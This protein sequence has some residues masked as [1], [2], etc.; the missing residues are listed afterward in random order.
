MAVSVI[1]VPFLS[2]DNDAFIVAHQNKEMAA[3]IAFQFPFKKNRFR[4]LLQ[5]L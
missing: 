2:G 3:S 1:H 5:I 4:S